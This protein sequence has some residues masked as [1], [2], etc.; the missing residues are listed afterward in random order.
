LS[1][2]R[3]PNALRTHSL[4]LRPHHCALP[5]AAPALQSVVGARKVSP[6][7]AS[8]V[9]RLSGG[10]PQHIELLA[11]ALRL[12]GVLRLN[13]PTGEAEAFVNPPPAPAPAPAPPA[14]AEGG[15]AASAAVVVADP[16]VA[17]QAALTAAFAAAAAA[18]AD[19][20]TLRMGGG[21][22]GPGSGLGPGS[23]SALSVS[24][25]KEKQR[26]NAMVKSGCKRAVMA[27]AMRLLPPKISGSLRQVQQC[28]C[29]CA[30]VAPARH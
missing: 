6:A 5:A 3:A 4:T 8:A 10:N 9:S 21:G 2:A 24:E 15:G 27:A 13:G 14:S 22:G 16:A 1:S 18:A 30:A 23:G 26:Q 11:N 20:A 28:P 7:L 19:A 25:A 17:E 29:P 12:G